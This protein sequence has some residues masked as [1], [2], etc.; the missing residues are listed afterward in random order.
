MTAQVPAGQADRTNATYDEQRR[1][2]SEEDSRVSTTTDAAVIDY[3]DLLTSAESLDALPVT[4]ARIASLIASG[5]ADIF[6]IVEVVSL[7]QALTAMLL[8]RAN[9]GAEGRRVEIR[10]V[11]DAAVRLGDRELLSMA[12]EASFSSIRERPLPAYGRAEG[13][14]WRHSVAA[15]LTADVIRRRAR[16]DVPREASTAA[17]LHDFGK[18]ILCNHF[19]PQVLEMLARA[20]AN[21]GVSVLEAERTVFGVTH[22]DIGGLVAAK[23]KLPHTIVDSIIHHH[24]ATPD[25]APVVATVSLAHAMVPEVVSVLEPPADPEAPPASLAVS[26]VESH[27]PLFDILRIPVGDYPGLLEAARVKFVAL[28]ERY[29]VA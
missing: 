11:R 1:A 10:T 8:R 3:H 25:L 15:S 28:S 6:E 18:V 27:A 7:D 2:R 17:L 26:P 29:S 12:M 20:A 19:G 16:A 23:W 24:D 5:D 21:D 13:Q 22:A 9:S 4:V 14:L